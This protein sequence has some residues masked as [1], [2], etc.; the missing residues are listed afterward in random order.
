MNNDSFQRLEI[1]YFGAQI[2]LP[3]KEKKRSGVVFSFLALHN[4]P[5]IGIGGIAA[6]VLSLFRSFS[7]IFCF[8]SHLFGLKRGSWPFPA[9]K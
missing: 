3:K 7:G 8:L 2:F 1:A 6:W 4:P 5:D 9:S